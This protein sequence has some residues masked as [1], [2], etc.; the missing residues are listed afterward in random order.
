MPYNIRIVSTYPPRRCGIGTF[1]RD[2][3]NALEHFT[4]EIGH[5]RV[6]VI[7]KDNLPY[8]IPV[9]LIIDQYNPQSWRYATTDIITRAKESTN[10]TIILLQHEFGLDPDDKGN[11]GAGTN[12]VNTAKAFSEKGLTVLVYLHTVLDN[13]NDHQKKVIQDL[14][15][16][17]DGLIVT[18]ESAIQILHS[19]L[20]GIEH[21]KLKHI[22]HG[23]RMS[24]P[25]QF[26]RLAIKEKFGI[27]NRFLITTIGLLSPDKGIQYGI[28]GFGKFLAE[29]CT[30]NQKN[31]IVYLIAGQYHPEF[32]KSGNGEDF[33]R[34]QQVINDAVKQANTRWCTVKSLEGIRFEEYDVIFLDAFLEEK[35]LLQLYGV[36]NVMLLPYLNMQQ[37][38]SG[39][40]A[41]TL[42]SGRAAIA[43]K[44]RYALELILSNHN[45]PGGL[46]IG[47]H[48]RGILVD[49][50]EESVEQ[51]AQALDYLVFNQ[52][53]RLLMEKQAHQRGYQMSWHNTA[54]ALLQY[55]NFVTE[56]N[57][58]HTGRGMKF[59]REKPSIYQRTKNITY[60]ESSG[61]K[62]KR[63]D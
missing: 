25:S 63:N 38:S 36:S 57:L 21:D 58:I 32:V 44:F 33:K 60:P 12:F 42:G 43:T 47:R 8:H 17:S 16:Y 28:R 15:H 46:V 51:I 7:D 1:S 41:D 22:D 53:Q 59:E 18:T 10:K 3:A 27:E 52:T 40:L 56:E 62:E 31:S 14:A 35:L 23:I 19:S 45:C 37:I 54:W 6:A 29:S 20:Y 13:P 55:V 61:Q 26:D 34:F 30:P 5:I 24:H 4:G 11:D 49:P 9:D 2:L 39:I 50:G 48:A